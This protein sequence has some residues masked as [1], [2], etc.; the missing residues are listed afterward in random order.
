MQRF[1]DS[2]PGAF[3]EEWGKTPVAVREFVLSL[4]VYMHFLPASFETRMSQRDEGHEN[5]I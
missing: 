4:A 1:N 5:I 2:R 3:V